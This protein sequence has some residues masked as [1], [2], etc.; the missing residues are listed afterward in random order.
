M[1]MVSTILAFSCLSLL[2][3]DG[4]DNK[5]YEIV[6]RDANGRLS[7]IN[8]SSGQML[9]VNKSSRIEDV[10]SLNLSDG[11]V[12]EIRSEKDRQDAALKIREWPECEIP[13]SK[14][15]V[16]LSTRYYKDRLLY[17]LIFFPS[18]ET[19][20]MKARTISINLRDGNGFVLEKIDPHNWVSVVND[21]GKPEKEQANGEIPMTLDNYMEIAYYDPSWRF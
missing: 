5:K 15:K 1:K 17:Q 2:G 3:C 16:Q 6:D 21:K 11:D 10:I 8:Q 20:A 14:Y 9:V 18:S 7:I 4:L 13:N 19:S 12:E